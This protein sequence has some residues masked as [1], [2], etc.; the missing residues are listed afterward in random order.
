MTWRVWS[1]DGCGTCKKAIAWMRAE[2][3]EFELVPIVTSPPARKEL[4]KLWKRSGLPIKRFFNTSG[5]SY[6]NGG[7]GQR[8]PEMTES[9]ALDA[10]AAD[11]KLIKRPVVDTGNTV[12]VGFDAVTWQKAVSA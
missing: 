5:Q 1:Y 10:L 2:G 11:G 4:E 12:L 7:F 8:L 9:E 3:V 6:R